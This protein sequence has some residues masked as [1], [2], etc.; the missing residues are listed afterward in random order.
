MYSI[1][2]SWD[3][4]NRPDRTNY[5]ETQ[6]A[7]DAIVADLIAK[8][9]TGAFAFEDNR[10]NGE[11]CWQRPQDW[12]VDPVAK[13]AS[14]DPP[15]APPAPAPRW[16]FLEFMERFTQAEQEAI[17]GAAMVNVQV[18]LWYDKAV[19]AK[20]II[21]DEPRTV[22]GMAALVAAGLLTAERRDE[23]LGAA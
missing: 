9:R 1:V 20:E 22:S 13:T 12:L 11:K 2:A 3:A 5:A 4:N 21:A 16:S 23:I 10:A 18:K 19:G 6:E 15:P 7:A 14:Y 8:G 17:A